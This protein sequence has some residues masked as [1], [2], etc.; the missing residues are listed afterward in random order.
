MIRLVSSKTL[1][2]SFAYHD[3]TDRPG[4]SGLQRPGAA[5]YT[6]GVA[7]F[8][9]HLD[10]IAA[11]PVRPERVTAIDPTAPGRHLLLTFDDGGKSAVHAADALSQ[12]GWRGHFFIITERIGERTF[13]DAA[14]IR[15]LHRSGH[16]IGSHSH[17]HPE[18]FREQTVTQMVAEWRTSCERL[19]DLLGEACTVASVPGGDISPRVLESAGEA[20][21]SFLFTSEP[22]LAP[23]SVNGCWV[24]G[25]YCPKVTTH[26]ARIGALAQFHGW[27][28]AMFMRRCKDF[29]RVV[30][31]GP[32]RRYAHRQARELGPVSPVTGR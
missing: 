28:R 13:L 5:P 3:V 15:Y 26:P 24:M 9:R 25:R 29:L 20:G 23:Q 21:L 12:R 16:V 30:L 19:A 6:L 10:A 18:I 8:E 4:E 22:T 1:V 17:T 27:G 11:G 14:E 32:Y 2:A 7:A 31:P